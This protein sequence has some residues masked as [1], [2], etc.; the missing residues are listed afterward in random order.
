MGDLSFSAGEIIDIIE[1]TNT[2]WWK[3]KT[4]KGDIGLFPSS[5]V[6]KLSSAVVPGRRFVPVP[7][8]STYD[9]MAVS[10]PPPAQSLEVEQAPPKKNKFGKYGDTV[11]CSHSLNLRVLL[12]YRFSWR[13]LQP[14]GLGLGRV[15]V[16]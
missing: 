7:T 15:S 13:N 2:D 3:G 9:P 5:Y 6:E 12:I 8:K 14:V 16:L 10:V 1:E 11:M 4:P